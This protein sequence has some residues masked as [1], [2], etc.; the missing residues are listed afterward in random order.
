MGHGKG[1]TLKLSSW[2]Y[3]SNPRASP[4]NPSPVWPTRVTSVLKLQILSSIPLPHP[5][6]QAAASATCGRQPPQLP[7]ARAS[8]PAPECLCSS[9]CHGDGSRDNCRSQPRS[10]RAIG[11]VGSIPVCGWGFAAQLL[12]RSRLPLLGGGKKGGSQG[13]GPGEQRCRNRLWESE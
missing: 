7:P 13:A 4:R 8:A 9:R 2:L 11:E 10:S 6:T 3:P 12:S 5:Y 1:C